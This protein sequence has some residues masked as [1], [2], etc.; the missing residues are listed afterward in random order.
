MCSL[1]EFLAQPD[2][3]EPIYIFS[4]LFFQNT[5]IFQNIKTL[6]LLLSFQFFISVASFL[7]SPPS[8]S[9]AA[10]LSTLHLS[11]PFLSQHILLFT[12]N[13][14]HYSLSIFNHRRPFFFLFLSIY[15][16]L[17]LSQISFFS[18]IDFLMNHNKIL[19]QVQK[20]GRKWVFYFF[21]LF[22]YFLKF[23]WVDFFMMVDLSM[24][25]VGL[26]GGG[27]VICTKLTE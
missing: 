2:R 5:L 4:I 15:L 27:F 23:F 24:A 9:V 1:V 20:N 12:L 3:I 6:L 7:P 18:I 13:L 16:L 10:S 21:I 19:H 26:R 11:F 14:S 17:F 25:E 22:T 8:I